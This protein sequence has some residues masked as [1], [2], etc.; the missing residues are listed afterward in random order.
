MVLGREGT[1]IPCGVRARGLSSSSP[2]CRFAGFGRDAGR[3]PWR[4]TTTCVCGIG[5]DAATPSPFRIT[6][7]LAAA[8]AERCGVRGRAEAGERGGRTGLAGT[9]VSMDL[10]S[11]STR[12]SITTAIIT[13]YLRPP[14]GGVSGGEANAMPRGGVVRSQRPSAVTRASIQLTRGGALGAV[15]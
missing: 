6:F 13:T 7:Q 14:R 15:L 4:A 1:V 12:C 11:A 10:T 9:Q 2:V 8:R 3:P 5:V